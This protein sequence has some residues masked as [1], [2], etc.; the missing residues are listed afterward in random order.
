[1]CL[2]GVQQHLQARKMPSYLHT[3]QCRLP[4]IREEL[5]LRVEDGN[6]R[7]RNTVAVMKVGCIFGHALRSQAMQTLTAASFDFSTL[8]VL[9]NTSYV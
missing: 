8:K 5:I 7:D 6:E 9:S 2:R 4:F 3:R 1:M